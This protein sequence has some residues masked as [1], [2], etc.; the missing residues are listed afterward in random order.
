MKKV[1]EEIVCDQCGLPGKPHAFTIDDQSFYLD[2]CNRDYKAL[3]QPLA[4]LGS[5]TG[6]STALS[7]SKDPSRPRKRG[8]GR[9]K[10]STKRAAKGKNAYGL[11]KEQVADCRKWAQEEGY[12]VKNMGPILEEYQLAYKKAKGL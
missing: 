3:V 12:P 4:K 9:P 7:P 8:P 2:L 10:G 5:S 1:I 11:T 6:R